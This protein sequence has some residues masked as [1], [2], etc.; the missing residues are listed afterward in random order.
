LYYSND[1]IA[2]GVPQ[3]ADLDDDGLPEVLLINDGGISLFE[4]DGTVVF[5]NQTPTN[6][7]DW[8]RPATVHDFDNDG[9]AEF[10]VSAS[11]H[12]TVYESNLD[13]V[14][15]ADV[16]D[17]SGLASGTAFDFLGDGGAEAM[18]GDENSLFVFDDTGAPVLT[19]PRESRTQ[20]EYPVV[21]DVDNDG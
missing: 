11:N 1:A 16:A 7:F 10:A 3:V 5:A 14:W 21:A 15:T 2:P 12:Y 9:L 17:L 8:R 13:I 4:H 18:Y 20:I 6:D 19:Q